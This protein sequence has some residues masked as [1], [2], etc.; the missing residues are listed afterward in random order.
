MRG[1]VL[2]TGSVFLA[3]ILAV[4]AAGCSSDGYSGSSNV[5]SSASFYYGNP[6]YNDRYYYYGYYPPGVIVVPPP[7]D[8]GRPVRPE[9]PIAKPPPGGPT[10]LPAG[11]STGDLPAA[12]PSS[13]PRMSSSSRA[14]IPRAPRGGG[15]GR[16]R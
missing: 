13:Q 8:G 6:W 3:M 14:S 11:P 7:R 15:G 1:A 4:I 10:T 2:R 5:S 12:R 16:R 9:Q